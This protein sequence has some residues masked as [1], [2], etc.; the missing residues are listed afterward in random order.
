MLSSVETN[1]LVGF[2]QGHNHHKNLR[3]LLTCQ[4]A[5][6]VPTVTAGGDCLLDYANGTRSLTTHATELRCPEQSRRRPACDR[7]RCDRVSA[8][9][10]NYPQG[11]P[12]AHL[13]DATFS[14]WS[15][16]RARRCVIPRVGIDF[17]CSPF[18]HRPND[19]CEL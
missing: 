3:S 1:G 2:M 11:R 12:L 13:P 9:T 17:L 5:N 8:R 10:P 16:T 7:D 18:S 19:R 14:I 6:C 4:L 15:S